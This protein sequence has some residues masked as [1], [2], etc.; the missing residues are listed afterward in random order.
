MNL[1]YNSNHIFKIPITMKILKYHIKY[2]IML[3]VVAFL[4]S[5]S[6]MTPVRAALTANPSSIN[7]SGKPG[8]LLQGTFVIV[9]NLCSSDPTIEAS[10]TS[11]VGSVAPKTFAA[12]DIV[13]YSFTI[14]P[15][16]TPGFKIIATVTAVCV[17]DTT[18]N[19][20]VTVN[21]TVGSSD[22]GALHTDFTIYGMKL[23]A[24]SNQTINIIRKNMEEIRRG[25]TN[26]I[27][28]DSLS[29]YMDGKKFPT[30]IFADLLTD[31]GEPLEESAGKTSFFRKFGVFVNGTIGFGDNDKTALEP[32]FHFNSYELTG[33]IDY[34][35]TDSF[36]MGLVL[37]YTNSDIDIDS[38]GGHLDTDGYSASIFGTYYV[39]DK[40]YID[41][42]AGLGI[43]EFDLGRNVYFPIASPGGGTTVASQR[44]NS[45]TEGLQKTIS[46]GCGYNFDYKAFKF[47]PFG[48][49]NYIRVDIDSFREHPSG[50][51][52]AGS[53]L[54]LKVDSD[55]VKS[56]ATAFGFQ[57]S[58]TV[59]TWWSLLPTLTPQARLEWMHEFENDR[60]RITANFIEDASVKFATLTNRP[61][62]NFLNF[63]IGLMATF[64]GNRS[65]SA[66]IDYKTIIGLDDFTS[67]K[68]TF[69]FQMDF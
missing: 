56:L 58:Y 5:L 49:V 46:L 6:I 37:D 33:G 7:L 4:L 40:F 1:F 27:R 59:K 32:G 47:G 9:S 17:D 63:N 15:N 21:I 54:R 38:T 67:H 16:A 23:A 39:K 19:A 28:L 43:T 3:A 68:I 60:R 31:G 55:D 61:D 24:R 64:A 65:K 25:G 41:G 44:M 18:Q 26:R 14:P 57:A 62:K 13:T 48:R 36:A 22:L 69:G 10:V 53:E 45:D 51:G 29:V 8:E 11:G 42:I 2:R 52:G 20:T 30:G 12:N 50:P 66:F 35:F 34:R